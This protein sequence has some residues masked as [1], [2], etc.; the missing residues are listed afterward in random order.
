[1]FWGAVVIIV[2]LALV[3]PVRSILARSRR[4]KAEAKHARHSELAAQ[5]PEGAYSV[6]MG[7][8][9][10]GNVFDRKRKFAAALQCYRQALEI[11]RKFNLRARAEASL[12]MI[13]NTFDDM[14]KADSA[15]IYYQKA[16]ELAAVDTTPGRVTSSLFNRG[17]SQIRNPETNDSAVAMLRR[18][19]EQAQAAGDSR[20]ALEITYN[21]GMSYLYAFRPDSCI[22]YLRKYVELHRSSLDTKWDAIVHFNTGF[23]FGQKREWDSA[24]FHFARALDDDNILQNKIDIWSLQQDIDSVRRW[25]GIPETPADHKVPRIPRPKGVNLDFDMYLMGREGRPMSSMREMPFEVP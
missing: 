18:A 9:G 11:E 25:G 7:L 17:V 13:G 5:T 14:G 1:M 16:Q 3:I 2:L 8:N 15:A 24:Y 22:S 4:M 20:Q 23:A 12:E 6:A 10:K 19:L 21:L